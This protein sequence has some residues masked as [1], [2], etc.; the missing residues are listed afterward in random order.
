MR[1][2]IFRVAVPIVTMILFPAALGA[3]SASS[4]SGQTSVIQTSAQNPVFGSVPEASPTPAV[5]QLTFKDAIERGLRHNLAGLLSEYN[6]VAAR[7]EK[8]QELSDLLPH[9][10]GDV[11]EVAQKE[12]LVALGL[13]PGGPFG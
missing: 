7:A 10:S 2:L 1:S 8:W 11:Q 3:Q 6:T 13:R 9:V 4:I 12:S 5:L